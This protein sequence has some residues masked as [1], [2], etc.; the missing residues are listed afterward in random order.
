MPKVERATLYPK[1]ER[2]ALQQFP[3]LGEVAAIGG[4]ETVDVSLHSDAGAIDRG[5]TYGF[6]FSLTPSAAHELARQ[7]T[8]VANR[9]T[10][11]RA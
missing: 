6:E 9:L 4:G 2:E 3:D 1:S 8:E 5:E 7:L 11:K 10:G